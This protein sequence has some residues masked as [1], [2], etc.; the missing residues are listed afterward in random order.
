MIDRAELALGSMGDG[1][2][3]RQIAVGVGTIF[4]KTLFFCLLFFLPRRLVIW[5]EGE[6]KGSCELWGG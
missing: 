4:D 1:K 3:A 2:M 6:R 5:V